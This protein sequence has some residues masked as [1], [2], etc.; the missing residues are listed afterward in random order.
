MNNT[1]PTSITEDPLFRANHPLHR[2]VEDIRSI[3]S[4][5]RVRITPATSD[6][7]GSF[8]TEGV[9][10]WGGHDDVRFCLDS[11]IGVLRHNEPFY[12]LDS[13]DRIGSFEI[14]DPIPEGTAPPYRWP[15]E[16]LKNLVKAAPASP[17]TRTLIRVKFDR[18]VPAEATTFEAIEEWLKTLPPGKHAAPKEVIHIGR[19]T[20]RSNTRSEIDRGEY[21]EIEAHIDGYNNCIERWTQSGTVRVPLSVFEE[22]ESSVVEY[23]KDKSEDFERDWGD[24]EGG[25][26]GGDDGIDFDT[27]LEDAMAEAEAKIR[28]RDGTDDED[29]E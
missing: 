20:P 12:H 14:L 24:T 25:E 7:F 22:G 19:N 29:D 18:P 23:V 1:L 8:P 11:W 3:P 5:T 26:Y 2:S 9:L 15:N 21:I 16:D 6:Y 28:E 27:D 10:Y 13:P 17:Y 4:G